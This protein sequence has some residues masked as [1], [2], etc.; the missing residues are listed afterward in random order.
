[1]M[2]DM[3]GNIQVCGFAQ[4]AGY[5]T[6]AI[7]TLAELGDTTHAGRLGQSSVIADK[8]TKNDQTWQDV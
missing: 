3:I 5:G 4:H 8:I 2:A 6:K 1:M 7:F